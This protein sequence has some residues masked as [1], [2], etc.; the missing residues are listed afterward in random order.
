MSFPDPENLLKEVLVRLGLYINANRALS[1]KLGQCP[2]LAKK[3]TFFEKGK[4][5][6]TSI[7]APP[8]RT[9]FCVFCMKIKALYNFHKRGQGS[10]FRCCFCLDQGLFNSINLPLEYC[11]CPKYGMIYVQFTGKKKHLK[12]EQE[13]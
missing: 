7:S 4:K 2:I 13:L 12:N 1:R 11:P 10:K 6:T 5:R 9:T 8:N 3:G